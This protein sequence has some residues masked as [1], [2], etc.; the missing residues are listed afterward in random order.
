MLQYGGGNRASPPKFTSTVHAFRISGVFRG[1]LKMILYFLFTVVGVLAAFITSRVLDIPRPGRKARLDIHIAAAAGV[2]FGAKI[3]VWISYGFSP[4][5]ILSGK[6]IMGGI[7]GAFVA[8]HIYK[9]ISNRQ[10]EAL[11]GRFAIPLAVAVGFGKIGCWFH[12][13]CGGDFI[14][15]PQLVESA[16][17]FT[18]AF[19]LY[20]FY[21]K[22]GR[23]DLLFPVY[24]LSYLTM[25][26]CI[27]FVRDEPEMAWGLTIYQLMALAFVPFTI[28]ILSGRTGKHA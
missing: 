16:F 20:V 27:E 5:L 14:V 4:E 9:Y 28:S 23:A 2:A 17:Q 11:G 12:G 26:F 19:A 8:M 3:P 18:M 1:A 22:T 6:S 10:G 25:R 15:P 13:C 21:R 7:L 24:L